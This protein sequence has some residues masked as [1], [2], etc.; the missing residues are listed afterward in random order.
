M[1]PSHNS[2]TLAA[3]LRASVRAQ[4]EATL[5]FQATSTLCGLL[6]ALVFIRCLSVPVWLR[7]PLI[8]FALLYF[9][10]VSFMTYLLLSLFMFVLRRFQ[11]V[12]RVLNDLLRTVSAH[13][14]NLKTVKPEEVEQRFRT[15]ADG[16]LDEFS[17]RGVVKWACRMVLRVALSG[18]QSVV[19]SRLEGI[20][21]GKGG[22]VPVET[23]LQLLGAGIVKTALEPVK[24]AVQFYMW[25]SVGG[26]LV[27]IGAPILGVRTFGNR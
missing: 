13:I 5:H 19:G 8:S 3:S 14:K 18:L 16:V 25:M 4:L 27:L 21:I 10:A 6:P 23:V 24:K 17:G 7:L 26:G 12:E 1:T 2:D 11:A 15:G 9:P 20:P 22:N